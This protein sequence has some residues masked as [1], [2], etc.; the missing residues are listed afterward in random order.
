M[1][2]PKDGDFVAYIETLQRESAARLA[3]Q[4]IVVDLA[5]GTK[6]DTTA[7]EDKAASAGAPATGQPAGFIRRD[8]DSKLVKAIVSGVVGVALLLA[9]LTRGGVFPLVVGVALLAYALPRLIRA[10]RET[11]TVGNKAMV[12]VVFG[13]SGT[14]TP[15]KGK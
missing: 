15:G 13:R 9:W 10:L 14:S 3:Q 7:F 2:E 4:H 11:P 8:R 12:D 6:G 5:F 1:Q